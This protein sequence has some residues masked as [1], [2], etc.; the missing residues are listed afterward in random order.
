[1]YYLETVY[2]ICSIIC[3]I[4]YCPTPDRSIYNIPIV[5]PILDHIELANL[6]N[7]LQELALS[8]ESR[9]S[10]ETLFCSL[11]QS[12][13]QFLYTT[14]D[15]VDVVMVDAPAGVLTFK[16]V[17]RF[18]ESSLEIKHPQNFMSIMNQYDNFK[19]DV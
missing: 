1:M 16:M 3:F 7:D 10:S 15:L 17:K 13:L 5:K 14:D 12:S 19:R 8:I 11:I 18:F 2:S 9:K 4:Q 6:R